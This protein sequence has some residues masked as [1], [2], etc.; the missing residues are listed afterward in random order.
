MQGKPKQ[1]LQISLFLANTHLRDAKQ[2]QL[3]CIHSEYSVQFIHNITTNGNKRT[4]QT[5]EILGIYM[6]VLKTTEKAV[7]C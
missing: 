4:D 6:Q 5:V 3:A 1:V 2:P 7:S